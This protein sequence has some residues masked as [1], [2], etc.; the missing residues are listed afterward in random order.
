MRDPEARNDKG[1]KGSRPKEAQ[2]KHLLEQHS[3]SSAASVHHPSQGM[4][5]A[6]MLYN[7]TTEYQLIHSRDIQ[8]LDG[9]IKQQQ[10]QQQQ[11]V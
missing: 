7:Q 11:H 2:S 4:Q 6:A 3:S 5:G 10:Q 8:A 9:D 1:K